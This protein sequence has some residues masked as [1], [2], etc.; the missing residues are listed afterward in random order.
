MK[1][2][3]TNNTKIGGDTPY[4]ASP[5]ERITLRTEL[6]DLEQNIDDIKSVLREIL[7][8][9]G[10]YPSSPEDPVYD[11]YSLKNTVNSLNQRLGTMHSHMVALGNEIGD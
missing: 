1:E 8:T 6:R 2:V 9:V 5:C 11:E 3:A 7:S 4:E 10:V